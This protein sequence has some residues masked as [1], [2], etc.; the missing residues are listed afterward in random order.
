MSKV[1]T[2]EMALLVS[3]GRNLFPM[4]VQMGEMEVQVEMSIW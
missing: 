2:V 1:V 3:A 4:E